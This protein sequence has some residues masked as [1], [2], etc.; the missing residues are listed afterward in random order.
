VFIV[1]EAKPSNY[2]VWV[3]QI[4]STAQGAYVD[5]VE[6]TD[7]VDAWARLD[8]QRLIHPK[9]SFHLVKR[10]ISDTVVPERTP[11]E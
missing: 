1:S 2:V 11:E 7:E 4:F 6:G 9:S 8:R 5:Y 3:V 10:V